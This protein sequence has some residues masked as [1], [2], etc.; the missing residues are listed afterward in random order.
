MADLVHLTIDGQ[1][2]TTVLD[3]DAIV[4]RSS[5]HALHLIRPP[6]AMF[7]DVLRQKL[8]WGKR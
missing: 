4:C 7:F 5:D 2:G 1:V 8:D 6:H 3:G